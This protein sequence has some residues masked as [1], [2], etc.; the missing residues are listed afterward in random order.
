MTVLRIV[1]VAVLVIGSSYTATGQTREVRSERLVLD[2]NNSHTV[3][4]RTAAGPIN[5]G[6]LTIP[7]PDGDAIIVASDANGNVGVTGELRLQETGGGTDY[8]GFSAPT[9]ASASQVWTLPAAD[10]N[11]GDALLTDGTGV[12]SW[13]RPSNSPIVESHTIDFPSTLLDGIR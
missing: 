4:I 12:L 1:V 13:G 10:G 2:D 3:I 11:D 5:G 7:D 9:D 6:T 8:V